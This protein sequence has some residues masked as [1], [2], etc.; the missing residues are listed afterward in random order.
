MSCFC[1]QVHIIFS[2][3][4][5]DWQDP[6]NKI[7]ILPL[8]NDNVHMLEEHQSI[9]Y[10]EVWLC[11]SHSVACSVCLVCLQACYAFMSKTLYLPSASFV[12]A[13]SARCPVGKG[14]M[15]VSWCRHRPNTGG[16]Q[17][18]SADAYTGLQEACCVPHRPRASAV[19]TGCSLQ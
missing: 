3:M 13:S 9:L 5:L 15:T 17:C 8:S 12:A 10:V 19:P 14:R 11:I 2:L 18:D 7:Q 1:Q 16:C 4:R 6:I